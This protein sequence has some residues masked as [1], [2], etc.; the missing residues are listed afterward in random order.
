MKIVFNEN[1]YKAIRVDS[2]DKDKSTLFTKVLSEKGQKAFN[3]ADNH[4]TTSTGRWSSMVGDYN[5]R[6][7][8]KRGTK[9]NLYLLLSFGTDTNY[10]TIRTKMKRKDLEE[11]LLKTIDLLFSPTMPVYI[12]IDNFIGFLNF[13]GR[14]YVTENQKIILFACIKNEAWKKTITVEEI[15]D[16]IRNQSEKVYKKL[17]KKNILVK[18]EELKMRNIIKCADN[19]YMLNLIQI[20]KDY[21]SFRNYP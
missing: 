20:M 18:I 14:L 3:E 16:E 1:F 5:R 12:D 19:G 11:G 8:W 9:T 2:K 7:N 10:E 15:I 6:M 13:S 17:G 4:N 21:N